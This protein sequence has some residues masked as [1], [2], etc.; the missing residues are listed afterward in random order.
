MYRLSRTT[1]RGKKRID[2]HP[3]DFFLLLYHDDNADSMKFMTRN[4][5]AD[6]RYIRITTHSNIIVCMC[7]TYI[8]INF[9]SHSIVMGS[10]QL[11]IRN[12]RSFQAQ[13]SRIV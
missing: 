10:I 11:S 8:H 5:D 6:R 4:Y 7:V 12:F 13:M 1:L 2:I 9:V 3:I